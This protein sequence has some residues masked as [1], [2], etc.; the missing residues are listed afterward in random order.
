MDPDERAH[1]EDD[2]DD[3]D[4]DKSVV[5]PRALPKDLPTSLEDRRGYGS[6]YVSQD[7]EYYDAWQGMIRA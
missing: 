3:D 5:K 1:H 4:G 7:T 6:E 2:D